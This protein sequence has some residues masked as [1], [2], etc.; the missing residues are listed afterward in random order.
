MKLASELLDQAIE[1]AT[2][3]HRQQ[4]RKG[5]DL[6]YIVHPLAVGMTLA[7]ANCDEEIIAAG[8]LHDT[9]EDTDITL[10]DIAEKFG[11]RVAAIV[12]GASEPDKTQ[13][14][15]NR[16]AH[17]IAHLRDASMDVRMVVC[18]DKLHNVRSIRR[19]LDRVGESVWDRFSRGRADQA[20][21]Y[22]S[23]MESLACGGSLP[24][25]DELRQ[26]VDALFGEQK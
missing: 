5:S 24:L 15:Q 10:A 14:W 1:V 22:H 26:A 21:Y 7:R 16:K 2:L 8:I 6:P 25:L 3:A 11:V 23:I 9:V 19:D 12:A 18:A 13:P 17:T 4:H 20:W